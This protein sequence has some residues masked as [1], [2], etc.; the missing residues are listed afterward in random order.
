VIVLGMTLVHVLFLAAFSYRYITV[1][2]EIPEAAAR[3]V[4]PPRRSR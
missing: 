3:P 2:S 1:E 4:R